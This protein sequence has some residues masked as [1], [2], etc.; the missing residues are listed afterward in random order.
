MKDISESVRKVDSLIKM[1]GAAL[2]VDDIR[3]EGMLY[4]KTVRST[5]SKANIKKIS[6]PIMPEGYHIVDHND[7]TGKNIVSIIFDD[8]PIF[9]HKTVSYYGE[10]IMLVVG[11]DKNVITNIISKIEIEYEELTP[12]FER[13]NSAV[14]YHFVKGDSAKAFKNAKKIIKYDYSSGYQ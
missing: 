4:A 14:N 1:S 10:P 3:V 5:K 9:A 11:E 8:M 13:T 6:L 12:T 7:I 2:Y